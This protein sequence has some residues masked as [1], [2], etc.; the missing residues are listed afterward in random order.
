MFPFLGL[1]SVP[2]P[3]K[4]NVSH[5]RSGRE[6]RWPEQPDP[7]YHGQNPEEAQV[8][9]TSPSLSFLAMA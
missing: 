8:P 5:S 7:E 3:L 6:S 1:L 2:F 9:T 4:L